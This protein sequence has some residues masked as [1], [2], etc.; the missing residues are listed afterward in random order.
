[1]PAQ[2]ANGT[3]QAPDPA[4]PKS[5]D[6]F[7]P[8]LYKL[9][10]ND[11][12]SRKKRSG[13]TT[14]EDSDDSSDSETT[15]KEPAGPPGSKVSIKALVERPNKESGETEVIEK[16]KYLSAQDDKKFADHAL[17]A[18]Q[19]FDAD[20]KLEKTTVEVNSP[21]IRAALKE[22]VTYYPSESLNFDGTEPVVFQKPYALLHHNRAELAAYAA[23]ARES[24]RAYAE[25]VAAHVDLLETFL[26]VEAGDEGPVL[27]KL[28]EAGLVTFD[29][30]WAIFK[31]GE[32]LLA[33]EYG[34]QR[35]YRC[36]KAGY[37][38]DKQQGR[39]F[40]VTCEFTNGDGVRFGTATVNIK[41]WQKDVV[42]GKGTTAI[43]RLPLF[44][45]KYVKE[46]DALKERL[47]ER[48][49]RYLEIKGVTTYDY[50]GLF[51]YL[52][53]PPFDFY[54]ECASFDGIWLP[55]SASDRIVVDPKTFVEEATKAAEGFDDDSDCGDPECSAEQ[56]N[57]P[58]GLISTEVDPLL[59]P[60]YVFGFSLESK[61]WCKFF[62]DCLVPVEWIPSAMDSLIVPETQRNLIQALA[63]SHRFPE[64]ARNEAALKGKGLIV[65]LHGTPGTGK[66]LTAEMVAEQTK[67]P[68]LK[69]ST[70]EL[71]S[72]GSRISYEL[73][74]LLTYASIW[75]AVVLIDEADVFL[76]ARRSG[77]EQF[78]Q[79][80]LVAIFLKQLEYFQGIL[81]MTSNRVSVFDP[82]IRS[83][84]HL[85]LQ[86]YAPDAPRRKLMWKQ[87][88][89][90][91][92]AGDK[93]LDVEACIETMQKA[94]MNGREI[95]NAVNTALTL[96]KSGDSRL[97]QDHLETV[98]KV[99][100]DFELT[101]RKI[102]IS[103]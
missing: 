92:P 4:S 25:A 74:R 93:D 33:S 37:G 64:Q 1:M 80:N 46:Q 40:G 30:L 48:G 57:K 9:L 41:L 2:Q 21:H 49:L 35:M 50:E 99:W 3:A 45:L 55:R 70:G 22:V 14:P 44:P 29:L 103:S 8:L 58:S 81:F 38:E 84:I 12:R 86:Y 13:S 78:E 89:G 7:I 27:R 6:E 77:P 76:E 31:P 20:R 90:R 42:V 79:N 101:L 15:P 54:N 65:L 66:T 83:R 16:E 71:G 56:T 5:M 53:K 73:Q 26:D 88:L 75:H 47:T 10:A 32:L 102:E 24:G 39:F 98:L 85:A 91:L 51:L 23:R 68:L 60:P 11:A 17:V 100:E 36:H 43:D 72:W 87:Q 18:K 94:E 96:A 62:V 63:T 19:I 52:K 59:C 97:R 95:A 67:R 28:T 34:H 61:E 82:A 69:V